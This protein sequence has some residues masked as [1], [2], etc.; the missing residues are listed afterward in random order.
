MPRAASK[1][2]CPLRRPAVDR[3]GS[4]KP[5]E[6]RKVGDSTPPLTTSRTAA[7]I[8]LYLRQLTCS[9][10][11]ARSRSQ[12]LKPPRDR[13]CPLDVARRLHGL[14]R[15]HRRFARSDSA[16][17]PLTRSVRMLRPTAALLLR[18][19]S[20]VALVPLNVAGVRVHLAHEWHGPR[21]RPFLPP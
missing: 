15:P 17:H 20:L 4:A 10:P 11:S 6:K 14:S 19:G 21:C 7:K 18:R 8:L 5:P 2:Y 16:D 13:C 3:R 12:R 9:C 1:A